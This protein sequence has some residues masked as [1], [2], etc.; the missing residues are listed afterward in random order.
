MAGRGQAST[1]WSAAARRRFGPMIV[2]TA[3]DW[4]SGS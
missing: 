2:V 4:L 3:L 1:F